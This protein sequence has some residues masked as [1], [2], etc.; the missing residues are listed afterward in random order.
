MIIYLGLVGSLLAAMGLV[1]LF[2]STDTALR[3]FSGAFAFAGL[4][5]FVI[6]FRIRP[7]G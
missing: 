1:G 4:V 5:L 6:A 7:R 3:L 2:F